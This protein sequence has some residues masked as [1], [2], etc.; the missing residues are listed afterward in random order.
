MQ[1]KHGIP[2]KEHHIHLLV[3]E[4]ELKIGEVPIHYGHH[5]LLVTRG[6]PSQA[7]QNIASICEEEP[8]ESKLVLDLGILDFREVERVS[9]VQVE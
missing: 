8:I 7:R 4:I 6:F 1:F 3:W 5:P 2:Q 9:E